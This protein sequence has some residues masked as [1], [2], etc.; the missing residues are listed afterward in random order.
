M[1]PPPSHYGQHNAGQPSCF[2]KMKMGFVMGF[3][4]GVVSGGLFGGFAALR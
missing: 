3:S 2:Q 1:P 4:V